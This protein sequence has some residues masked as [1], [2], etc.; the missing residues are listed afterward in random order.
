MSLVKQASGGKA[1]DHRFGKRQSGQ[2]PYA[3][4]L[5]ARFARACRE[6]SLLP[7]TYQQKLDC[8]SFLHPAKRQLGLAF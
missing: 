1:Y 2:G 3:D 4:M 7:D 6:F 8:N 5:A